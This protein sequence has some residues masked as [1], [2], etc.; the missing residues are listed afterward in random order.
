MRKMR[1]GLMV[2]ILAWTMAASPAAA[3][4]YLD[5]SIGKLGRG[6]INI[7]TLP[8]EFSCAIYDDIGKNPWTGGFTGP[9]KGALLLV[10]RALVGAL[11]I[12]TFMIPNDPWIDP[13]C[14]GATWH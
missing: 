4:N 8:A 7:I 11:E 1:L 10:R 2:L 13:V 3:A 12:A 14:S 6:V 5:K 9:V